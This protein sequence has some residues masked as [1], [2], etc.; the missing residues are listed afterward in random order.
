MSKSKASCAPEF[1]RRMIELVRAGQVGL[2]RHRCAVSYLGDRV[3]LPRQTLAFGGHTMKRSRR[4]LSL[5]LMLA[6]LAL[7]LFAEQGQAAKLTNIQNAKFTVAR[8]DANAEA[9]GLRREAMKTAFLAPLKGSGIRITKSSAYAF[10]IKA[11][12]IQFIDDTCVTYVNA[13][14]LL[15][16]RY[17]NPATA[18]DQVGIIRLWFDGRL[19]ATGREDHVNAVQTAFRK[20]GESFMKAWLRDQ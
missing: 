16:E 13:E 5:G 14:L 10:Y 12:S 18:G 11:T 20:L 15:A 6:T 17:F 2:A 19:H 7:G 3:L 4:S 1:R 8:L 9:C